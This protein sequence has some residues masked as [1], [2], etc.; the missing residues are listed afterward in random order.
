MARPEKFIA[1]YVRFFENF[2]HLFDQWG[3]LPYGVSGPRLCP[4]LLAPNTG[5]LPKSQSD[6]LAE[7]VFEVSVAL[8]VE[9]EK[10]K[11][12]LG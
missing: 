4:V 10:T 6:L 12:M 11:L 3:A 2:C 9:Q 7:A 8:G 5:N 1:W